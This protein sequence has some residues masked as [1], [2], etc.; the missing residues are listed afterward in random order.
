MLATI[1]SLALSSPTFFAS[2]DTRNVPVRRIQMIAQ[3]AASVDIESASLLH[4]G[5]GHNCVRARLASHSRRQHP[6]R[7]RVRRDRSPD[8]DYGRGD[9]VPRLKAIP[10]RAKKLVKFSPAQ[11]AFRSRDYKS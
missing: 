7:H 4:Y 6:Q 11:L 10:L 2:Y 8:V 5:D 3:P 9:L 1:V